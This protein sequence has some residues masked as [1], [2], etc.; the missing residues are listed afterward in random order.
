MFTL[1]GLEEYAE[2]NLSVRAYTSAGPG[3]YSAGVVERTDTDGE[4]ATN[5]V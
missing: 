5:I 3:P 2:Y 4:S 1:N